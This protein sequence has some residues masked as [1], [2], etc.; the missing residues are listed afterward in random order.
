MPFVKEYQ[1]QS[2]F[3]GGGGVNIIFFFDLQYVEDVTVSLG[4]CKLLVYAE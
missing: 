3:F 4:G 1:S 2:I